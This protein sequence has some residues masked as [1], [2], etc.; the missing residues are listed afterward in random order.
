M[1]H[2]HPG[3]NYGHEDLRRHHPSRYRLLHVPAAFIFDHRRDGHG[4]RTLQPDSIVAGAKPRLPQH[5]QAVHVAHPMQSLD[6]SLRSPGHHLAT[7]KPH[8]LRGSV[9]AVLRFGHRERAALLSVAQERG[10][11]PG[12]HILLPH[13]S[14]HKRTPAAGPIPP[15]PTGRSLSSRGPTSSRSACGR[16]GPSSAEARAR[17]PTTLP[18]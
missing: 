13:D 12:R 2:R 4:V 9:R 8:R 15:G 3:G 5:L 14:L 1:P 17:S 10:E 18:L 11:H 16:T 6:A 7:P